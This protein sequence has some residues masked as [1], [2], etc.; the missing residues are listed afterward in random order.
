MILKK[1]LN[2]SLPIIL[3]VTVFIIGCTKMNHFSLLEDN[4]AFDRSSNNP[5]ASTI[6]ILDSGYQI[7]LPLIFI[8]SI[9]VY[10]VSTSGNDSNPG[11]FNLPWRTIQHAADMV[12]PG[13]TV[14]VRGGVYHE[15]I[16]T[17]NGGT[18]DFPVRYMAYPGEVPI[19]DGEGNLPP[20]AEALFTLYEEADY[21]EIS[22]FEIRNSTYNGLLIWGSHVKL[23]ELYVHH[24]QSTA[25]L[26]IGNYGAI[27]NCRVH[28]SNLNNEYGI[29][30]SNWGAGIEIVGPLGI[31]GQYGVISNCTVWETWGEGIN[32]HRSNN[33]TIDNNIVHDSLAAN[34]YVSDATN[35]LVQRNFVYQNPTSYVFGYGEQ[36]GIM[37]GDESYRPPS[38]NITIIN[39]IAYGN[40]RNFYWWNGVLGGGMVN[41][42]IA[43]NT[44]VNSIGYSG[45]K[46]NLGEH[47][48]VRLYNNIYVQDGILPIVDLVD[49]YPELFFSN[50]LWSKSP[51]SLATGPGDIIG[52]P[53]LAKAGQPFAP[54]WF[55]LI[56]SSPAVNKAIDL[57]EVII[58]YFGHFRDA[59]HDIG[60][61]EYIPTP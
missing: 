17:S 44:F 56:N 58:D 14:Y 25:I 31:I 39:N 22:G 45:I 46:I 36:V 54:E 37:M 13:D 38:E 16:F 55:M 18:Q 4:R 2:S 52:D 15:A 27:N 20:W 51:N 26:V 19:I 42:L 59:S 8:S 6:Q 60:A 11:T 47:Q 33:V 23:D 61:I 53:L 9:P 43:N 49:T 1:G 28:L 10:Y 48:D 24:T 34:I 40:R 7:Y 57:P 41:V 50:N 5:F 32:T 21:V 29:L 3:A 30:P 12:R 35:T